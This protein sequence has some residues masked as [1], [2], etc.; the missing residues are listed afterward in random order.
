MYG[1][2]SGFKETGDTFI[3]VFIASFCSGNSCADK[4]F[5][6]PAVDTAANTGNGAKAGKDDTACLHLASWNSHIVIG[7]FAATYHAT[8]F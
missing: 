2:A 1:G 3:A 4:L 7:K 8:H 5:R 6:A